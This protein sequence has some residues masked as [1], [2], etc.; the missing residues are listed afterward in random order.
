MENNVQLGNSMGVTAEFNLKKLRCTDSFHIPPGTRVD[1]CLH[2]DPIE[3]HQ[4]LDS[5]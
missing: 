1:M 2:L 5:F 3:F 4:F